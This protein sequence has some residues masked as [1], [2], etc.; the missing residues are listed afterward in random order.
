[1]S[2][3]K[4]TEDFNASDR[5]ELRL[6]ENSVHFL[7]G[8]IDENSVFAAMEWIVYE[9]LD[10]KQKKILTL[11]INT[12]GG[13]LYQAFALIDMMKTSQHTIRV[14]GIG[15]VM[16]AGF[17]IFAAGTDGERYA[18]PNASFMCHQYSDSVSG[19]HHDL[20][21]TMRDGELMNERMIS[22]LK[23]ATGLAPSVIRKKLLSPTD[24][25]LTAKEMVE[26]GIANHILI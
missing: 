21:A 9:N 7:T 13:D 16:S 4:K 22:V 3:P 1:M 15:A 8:E 26:L 5:I 17:L 25:Y 24:T 10:I 6:L 23:D 14:V 2:S 20:K 12:T 18:A 11:Y 19:K